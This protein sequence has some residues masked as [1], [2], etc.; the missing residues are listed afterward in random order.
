MW[1]LLVASILLLAVIGISSIISREITKPIRSLRD[2]MRKVQN[3]QFDTHVEVIT[4][5]EIG[6]LGRSFNLM[7]SEIQALMEQ[8]VYEQKQKRKSELKALQA[9]INPHFLYNTLNSVSSLIKMNCPDEAFIMIQAIGTFY[10]TS[11]SDGK[12][13]IPLEQEITN[14]ENYIKI[15]KVRYGN[16]I[17]YEIDIENEILQEWIVKLTLQPLIENSIYHG[18]K[19][20]R[21]KGII[22]IKGWK[23][24]N[25][26]FI[27]VSDNGL[28]IPEEKLEELWNSGNAPWKVWD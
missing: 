27:Q 24:K 28:G 8:N 4:E 17:E 12:T 23:E 19:E 22:R 25:K 1:Y 7:T 20:M 21:G 18:I 14:I 16:K 26:V 5:N 9:Q 11:L 13:L 3:G 15:Q 10:R 6:S 2:S